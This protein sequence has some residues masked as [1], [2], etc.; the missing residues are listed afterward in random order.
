MGLWI[1]SKCSCCELAPEPPLGARVGVLPDVL[2]LA[3]FVETDAAEFA[4]VARA[5]HT[6]PFSLR[7][8]GVVVI[9]PDRAVPQAFRDPL[10]LACVLR[11]DRA[12]EPVDG[13]IGQSDCLVLVGECLDGE[14]RTERF[15]SCHQHSRVAA[16]QN[17]WRV[18]EAVA[19]MRVVRSVS[20]AS[21]YRAF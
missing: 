3:V 19:Q 11:P 12:C 10:S 17:G 6:A 13:V 4:A 15:L 2:D 21:Q 9:D 8:V 5:L 16:V 18:E 1:I 14:Y 7:H 20:A